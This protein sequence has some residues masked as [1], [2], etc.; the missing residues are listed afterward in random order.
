MRLTLLFICVI[1]GIEA[2]SQASCTDAIGLD[3]GCSGQF[4]ANIYTVAV[5]TAYSDGACTYGWAGDNA[6]YFRFSPTSNFS[7]VIDIF[8][9]GGGDEVGAWL[10]EKNSAIDDALCLSDP[11]LS[12]VGCGHG[13][14]SITVDNGGGNISFDQTKDYVLYV[15]FQD[16]FLEVMA[17]FPGAS[18]S[19]GAPLPI[20]LQHFTALVKNEVVRL[21]WASYSE[22]NN[23][24][25][26]IERSTDGKNFEV[27]GEV[28]GAG[29]SNEILKYHLYDR[30][31]ALGTN[32]YRLKQVDF[33]GKYE[34]FDIRS[35]EFNNVYGN[36]QL[37]QNP[38]NSE[39]EFFINRENHGEVT[40]HLT[41][42]NGNR[43]NSSKVVTTQKQTFQTL[44]LS[45]FA[46]GMYFLQLEVQGKVVD[47]KKA[48]KQ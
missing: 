4:N 1:F 40:V 3:A 34:Y 16:N 22:S 14:G 30:S 7:D 31:P 33:D 44:D 21:D 20:E 5:G 36:I 12:L 10:Y 8:H 32:Y 38:V 45:S 24:Y 13:F 26:L 46:S 48:M 11:S 41:D 28:P 23:H 15:E 43:I 47:V 18:P 39:L 27:I 9:G 29:N 6:G 37:G 42:I 17:S 19:C 2:Y 25:Y 35:V